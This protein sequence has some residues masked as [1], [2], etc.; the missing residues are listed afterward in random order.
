MGKA[1][2]S[3]TL[4]IVYSQSRTIYIRM[5]PPFPC[6]ED[7]TVPGQA[8][9]DVKKK[10]KPM[11]PKEDPV[12]LNSSKACSVNLPFFHSLSLGTTGPFLA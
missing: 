11:F 3:T 8:I 4:I 1:T 12:L 5:I 9:R 6:L 2:S 10:A 7:F